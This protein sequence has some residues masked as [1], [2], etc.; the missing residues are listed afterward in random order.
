MDLLKI[1]DCIQPL[2]IFAKLFRLSV[3]QG[4]EYASDETRQNP[5][6]LS[7]ISQ[8]NETAMSEKFFQF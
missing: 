3:L 1:V 5:G 2:S 4:Y 8:K 7:F 6:I